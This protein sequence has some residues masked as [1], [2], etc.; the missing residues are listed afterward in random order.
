MPVDL[1]G[2]DKLENDHYPDAKDLLTCPRWFSDTIFCLKTEMELNWPESHAQNIWG[3]FSFLEAAIEAYDSAWLEDPTNDLEET[4]AA[5]AQL[6]YSIS[7]THIPSSPSPSSP[8]IP[9]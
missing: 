1:S 9:L 2:V 3:T 4:I 6:P 7:P 5:R 8:D